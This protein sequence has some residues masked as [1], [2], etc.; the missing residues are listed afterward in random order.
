MASDDEDA[1][2][3]KVRAQHRSVSFITGSELV[4]IDLRDESYRQGE[5]TQ[6]N[7]TVRWLLHLNTMIIALLFDF[8]DMWSVKTF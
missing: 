3:R 4:N 2:L 1:L 8:F 5:D 6:L 7:E